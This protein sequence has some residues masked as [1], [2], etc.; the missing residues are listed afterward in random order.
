MLR[1]YFLETMRRIDGQRRQRRF[2]M[3]SFLSL[4]VAYL[5]QRSKSVL[6]YDSTRPHR[7]LSH[8]NPIPFC[9][10]CN[11]SLDI[12]VFDGAVRCWQCPRNDGIGPLGWARR[13]VATTRPYLKKINTQVGKQYVL[14]RPDLA[15]FIADPDAAVAL[16]KSLFWEMQA[17]SDFGRKSGDGK[18]Y[19][20]A[21][22]SCHYRFGADARS[23]NTEA[24]AYQAWEKFLA[25]RPSVPDPGTDT[26]NTKPPF[27]QRKQEFEPVGDKDISADKFRFGAPDASGN[28]EKLNGLLSHEIVGSQGIERRLFQGLDSATGKEK[29]SVIR[30]PD[31]GAAAFNMF[32]VDDKPTRQVTGRN[33]PSVINAVFYDRQFHDGRAESTFNGFSIFGDFDKRVILKKAF[34]DKDGKAVSYSPVS[35]A[36][37]N[38]SLGS[39]SVGPVVNEV[40]MSYQGRNFHD[41]ALKLLSKQPLAA[42]KVDHTDSILAGYA[43]P[44]AMGLFDPK[45]KA[46][47]KQWLVKILRAPWSSDASATK[48]KQNGRNGSRPQCGTR[49]P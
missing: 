47:K 13:R 37:V 9:F 49:L 5:E 40:E 8:E 39:Q 19:G 26:R 4:Y 34:L 21:C 35:V 27:T 17:G 43:K 42:Q 25:P 24:I 10:V 14:R 30:K 2:A 15:E 7:T 28:P 38:A 33:S 11:D 44:S 46:K 31:W 6:D 45:D 41:L 36:I 16:G 12:L 23:R 22:A 3:A 32:A 29:F 20:T 18:I 48:R 1:F